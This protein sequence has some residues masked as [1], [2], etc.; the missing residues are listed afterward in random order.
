MTTVV[1]TGLGTVT[2]K[3]AVLGTGTMTNDGT[4]V[5][6]TCDGTT[7]TDGDP[8]TVRICDEGIQVGTHEVGINTGLYQV[9]GTTTGTDGTLGIETGTNVLGTTLT[10]CWINDGGITDGTTVGIQVT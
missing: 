8:G 9:E 7:T 5:G 2:V 6:T 4:T 10:Q 1:I 3:I